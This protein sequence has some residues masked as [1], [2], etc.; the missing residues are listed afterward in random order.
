M[1]LDTTTPTAIRIALASSIV[2]MTPRVYQDIK[3]VYRKE[4]PIGGEPRT[5][6]IR[7]GPSVER[8]P[9]FH[10]GGNVDYEYELTIEAAYGGLAPDKV[11]EMRDGYSFDL[12]DLIHP[13]PDGGA[14]GIEGVLPMA[15]P[16]EPER[17]IDDD[18]FVVIA[19]RILIPYNRAT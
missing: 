10:G 5:F 11:D 1:P 14:T 17:L 13:I 19:Y 7:N 3:W 15:G 16:L 8:F 2:G 4:G 6:T 9:G 12:W 18:G